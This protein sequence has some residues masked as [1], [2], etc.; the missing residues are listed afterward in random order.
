[1]SPVNQDIRVMVAYPM[2]IITNGVGVIYYFPHKNEC[3]T[4]FND[5]EELLRKLESIIQHREYM[6]IK[7]SEVSKSILMI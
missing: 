2:I 7:I 1:M 5:T 3:F 4:Q 6:V